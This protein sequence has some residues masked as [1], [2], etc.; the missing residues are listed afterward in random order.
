MFMII[1]R[2]HLRKMS[3]NYLRKN[4]AVININRS[5]Y[6]AAKAERKKNMEIQ[7][8]KK[9]INTIEQQLME[10]IN[11]RNSTTNS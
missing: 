6:L 11:E 5:E 8:L 9:R 7:N 3:T 4:T 1:E 2:L 10:L